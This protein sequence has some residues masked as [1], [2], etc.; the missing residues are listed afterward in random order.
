MNYFNLIYNGSEI[1]A[2][3][4]FSIPIN[5]MCYQNKRFILDAQSATILLPAKEVTTS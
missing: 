2:G 3:N 1:I 5:L 4:F